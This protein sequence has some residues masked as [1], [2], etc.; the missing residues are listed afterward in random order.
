MRRPRERRRSRSRLV[1]PDEHARRGD[2]GD[3]LL[4][5]GQQGRLVVEGPGPARLAPFY[6]SLCL[7]ADRGFDLATVSAVL[8][9]IVRRY[10]T[11]RTSFPVIDAADRPLREDHGWPGG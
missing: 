1:N 9:D 11:L 10:E 6:S 2:G 3:A 8:N 4:S 5:L 7:V